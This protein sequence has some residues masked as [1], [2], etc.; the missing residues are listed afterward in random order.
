MR[1]RPK[2]R[3][4]TFAEPFA[5]GD[6]LLP[7]DATA[8]AHVHHVGGDRHESLAQRSASQ[9]FG[10]PRVMLGPQNLVDVVRP[11]VARDVCHGDAPDRN[12]RDASVS[13][14]PRTGREM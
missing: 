5:F 7:R 4:F 1:R 2:L 12:V 13:L 3:L 11:I 9:A 10:N 14:W 6:Q 8:M